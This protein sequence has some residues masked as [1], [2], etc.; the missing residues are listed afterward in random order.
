M[1]LG[2]EI[3]FTKVD[4]Q[5]DMSLSKGEKKQAKREK[6]IWETYVKGEIF[7]F[8]AGFPC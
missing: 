3:I 5:S 2:H 1:N 7:T 6:A 4:T 8:L